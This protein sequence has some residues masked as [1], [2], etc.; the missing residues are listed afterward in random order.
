[1]VTI[2]LIYD[3][4]EKFGKLIVTYDDGYYN[5]IHRVDVTDIENLTF[6]DFIHRDMAGKDTSRTIFDIKLAGENKET[7]QT[8]IYTPEMTLTEIEQE[9]G[10]KIR[11]KPD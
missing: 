6:K 4:N 10:Y 3:D 5:Y 8:Q 9:L 7:Q 2:S 1:M 11:L